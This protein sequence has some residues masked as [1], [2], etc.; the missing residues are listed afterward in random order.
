MTTKKITTTIAILVIIGAI[1]AAITAVSIIST[2]R[3][4]VNS[5]MGSRSWSEVLK[6]W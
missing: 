6:I 3:E 4:P 2:P 1:A 5:C